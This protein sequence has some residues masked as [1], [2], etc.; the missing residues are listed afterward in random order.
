MEAVKEIISLS[1][2]ALEE[3]SAEKASQIEPLEEVID[4]LDKVLKKRHVKRLRKGKCSMDMGFILSD[5]CTNLERVADHCSNI[6]V[7]LMQED[8][9]EVSPHGYL[10][11]FRDAENEMFRK[12]YEA[13]TMK[14]KLPEKEK[15]VEKEEE[16]VL[17]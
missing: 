4:D 15:N 17:N 12:K 5:I 7:S 1:L 10:E 11:N 13:Y 14:Y 9:D 2:E 3:E 8:E 6:G 16:P